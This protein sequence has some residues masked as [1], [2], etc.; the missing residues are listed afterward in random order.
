MKPASGV[1]DYV[2]SEHSFKIPMYQDSSFNVGSLTSFCKIVVKTSSG[3][4]W[5]LNIQSKASMVCTS[6]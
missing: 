1:C 3:T 2:D 5:A 4:E 6:N